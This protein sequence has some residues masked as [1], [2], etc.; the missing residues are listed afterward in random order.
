MIK[1]KISLA[2]VLTMLLTL[3]MPSFALGAVKDYSGHWAEDTIDEWFENDLIE[4]YPDGTFVPDN[5]VTRAEFMTMVNSAFEFTEKAEIDFSDVNTSAWY[6]QEVQKAV[7]ADYIIGDGDKTARPESY[8]TRQEAALI[9]ARIKDLD[10]AAASAEIFEDFEKIATW[11]VG[12]VGAATKAELMIGYEDETF[13][14]TRNITRAESLV[15]VDRSLSDVEVEVPGT[16]GGS[17]G[18]GGGDDGD[19]TTQSA[20]LASLTIADSTTASAII[21][22]TTPSAIEGFTTTSSAITITAIA[23]DG[24]SVIIT[25]TTPSGIA[26]TSSAINGVVNVPLNTTGNYTINIVV[27]KTDTSTIDYIDTIYTFIITRE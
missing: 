10:D 13:R 20:I 22:I 14:P 21:N 15:T 27:S 3:M 9:I 7:Q 23:A 24:A 25:V 4:G 18:G 17:G 5:Q 19:V 1:R 11:S 26:T 2:L 6:Y 8:I 12:G 16:G